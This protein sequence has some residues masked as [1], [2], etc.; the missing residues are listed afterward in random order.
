MTL[1]RIESVGNGKH[2]RLTLSRDGTRLTAMKFGTTPEQFP[3][4]VGDTV[5]ASVTL[6]RN[7]YRG[8]VSVSVFVRDLRHADT[9]QESVIEALQQHDAV[10]RRDL[11]V[12]LAPDRDCAAAVY[13]YLKRGAYRG[14]TDAFMRAT[15]SDAYTNTDVLV[16]LTLLREAGLID[17]SNH[18]DTVCASVLPV[19][20]KHDLSATATAQYLQRKEG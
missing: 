2:L 5:N 7:E 1:E 13:R 14:S 8:T 4:A 11:L 3:F 19:E 10:L 17:F 15:A 16:S 20:G 6:D 12:S 9:D 18:G